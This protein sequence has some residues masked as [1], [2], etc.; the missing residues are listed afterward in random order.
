[1]LRE[2]KREAFFNYFKNYGLIGGKEFYVDKLRRFVEYI[3]IEEYYD[4]NKDH[5]KALVRKTW[6]KNNLE[7]KTNNKIVSRNNA[8]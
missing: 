5:V 7:I 1:M 6:T 8:A 2:A 3:E 4:S